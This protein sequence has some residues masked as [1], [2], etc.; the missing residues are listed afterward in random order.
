MED[1]TRRFN[2]LI[3]SVNLQRANSITK[4]N[5]E[6]NLKRKAKSFDKGDVVWLKALNI[7]PFRATKMK[8]LGPFV[9]MHKI[10]NYTFKLAKLETPDVCDRILH[11]SHLELFHSNIDLTPIQFPSSLS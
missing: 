3:E 9:I 1:T 2:T 5:E 11:A 8:Q 10:N 7:S 4:R 6:L